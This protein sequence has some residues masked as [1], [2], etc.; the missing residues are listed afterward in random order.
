MLEIGVA[1]LRRRRVSLVVWTSIV[2]ALVAIVVAFYPSIK[3]DASLDQ[4][5]ADFPEAVKAFLG[6]TSLV[7]PVGYLT[8]R[9]FAAI[10]PATFIGFTIGRGSAAIAGEEEQHTL[11]LT[12][13]YPV[14]RR[15]VV[16]QR[17]AAMNLELVVL[18]AAAWLPLVALA[19][20]SSI[21]IGTGY[22]TIAVVESAV[23][24]ATFGAVALAIGAWTGKRSLASGIAAGIAT[25]GYIIDS[26]AR[27]TDVL[28]PLRPFTVW[29]WYSDHQPLTDGFDPTGMAVLI[30]LSVVLVVIGLVR[31]ER[32]DIRE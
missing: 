1:A 21:D 28:R 16:L 19:G 13:A 32:R 5:F 8:G 18:A 24:A 6:T 27:V 15:A 2:A 31:F 10:L 20:P 3:G 25:A 11:N 4:T 7:T 29:R 9:L 14:G 26:L 17:L 23:I 30:L 22:L 12:L